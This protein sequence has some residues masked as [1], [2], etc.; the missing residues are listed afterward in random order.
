MDENNRNFLLAI[1]L[2][3][4]VLFAW[5]YFF[6]PQH[7]PAGK[8]PTE[9]SQQQQQQAEPGPPRPGAQTQTPSAGGPPPPRAGTAAALT[10][11]EALAQS[12]RIAIDTAALIGSI[13][14]KGGRID[15]LTL[16]DYRE[17]VEPDSPNVILLSPAGGPHAYYAEHGFVG[18]TN[19]KDLSLPGADTVWKATSQ[20]PLTQSSPVT[21][22]YD[23]GK[24]V[25]CRRTI[26]VDDKYMFTVTDKVA[27]SG[28][29]PVTLYPYALV[30][31]HE[32][33]HV[34]GYYILH[35]GLIGVVDEGLQEITYKKAIDKPPATFKSNEGWLGITDKYWAAVVIPEQGKAFE[36]RLSGSQTDG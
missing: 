26:A 20:A 10:R 17:T 25:T 29:E 11:E 22:T 4:G 8:P 6:V 9:Q 21:L 15:D 3:I 12:P 28:S 18:G 33:P 23:N 5:Q 7:P 36:A 24:A 35:E 19:A 2:S 27:N 14:L 13:A 30:S 31:R 1:L 34:G 16:K 32:T